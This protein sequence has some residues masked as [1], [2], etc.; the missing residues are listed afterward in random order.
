M[1]VDWYDNNK[2]IS[3]YWSER[4]GIDFF[5]QLIKE[6]DVI[7]V[8][9]PFDY[10]DEINKQYGDLLFYVEYGGSWKSNVMTG[11]ISLSLS[12]DELFANINKSKRYDISRAKK[13]G[14]DIEFIDNA[15]MDDI[16]EYRRFY[17]MYESKGLY[18]NE[19][20]I[21][22]MINS[23]NFVIGRALI[24]GKIIV[25]QGYIHDKNDGIVMLFANYN[26]Q[27][28]EGNMRQLIARANERLLFESFIYF[29]NLG[30]TTFDC[31]GMPLDS[32]DEK[33][34]SI[35]EYKKRFGFAETYRKAS[36]VFL[37]KEYRSMK[38]KLDEIIKAEVRNI[39]VWGSEGNF[40]KYVRKYLEVF[41]DFN[42]ED[43]DNKKN[44]LDKIKEYSFEDSLI[45]V[46]I[47]TIWKDD[48]LNNRFYKLFYDNKRVVWIRGDIEYAR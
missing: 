47:S 19:F 5:C 26:C 20:K 7:E 25:Q 31:G 33:L 18:Y 42:L 29:K 16:N 3:I 10:D 6:Y 37:A 9:Y 40:G 48:L 35:A 14:I 12:V 27:V 15:S 30:Y 39:I 34:K 38:Q 13:E 8:I 4:L 21:K 43:V 44:N 23:G 11:C 46:C 24:N 2:N 36:F 32:S 45:V 28:N 41:G 17:N 22:K 1:V